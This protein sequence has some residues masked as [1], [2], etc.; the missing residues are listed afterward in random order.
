MHVQALRNG[1]G[2]TGV[3]ELGFEIYDLRIKDA[4]PHFFE[5]LDL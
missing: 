4:Y 3:E 5:L 2:E 1:D